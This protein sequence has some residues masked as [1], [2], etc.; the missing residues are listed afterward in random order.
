MFFSATCLIIH[1]QRTKDNEEICV[2]NHFESQTNDHLLVCHIN[3][4]RDRSI[5]IWF[6]IDPTLFN[7]F[8]FYRFILR[9][10]DEIS[11]STNHIHLLT[12]FTE[13]VDQNN[14]LRILNLNSGQYEIC[15]DFQSNNTTYIYSPRNACIAIRIGELLHRS[16]KQS[17]IQLFI[18]LITGIILFLL[19]G[20]V[21]QH[22]KSKQI[23]RTDSEQIVTD[24]K[25]KQSPQERSRS[26][27]ILSSVIS[28]KQRLFRRY[29]D[30]PDPSQIRQW[31]RNRAFRHR[32]STQDNDQTRWNQA[33][34]NAMS[35][36]TSSLSANDIYIIPMNDCSRD[37]SFYL[38]PTKEFY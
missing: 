22:V 38:T 27:S 24:N 16:F 30:Q 29:I 19:L 32:I 35:Q 2:Q 17:S 5:L 11:L 26:S 34:S 37:I 8:H 28:T 33:R 9:T 25:K 3:N 6:K 7:F 21:V 14:S 20:L 13:L 31:A 18:A 10:V 12:N 36:N 15:L 4:N 23:E 1:T